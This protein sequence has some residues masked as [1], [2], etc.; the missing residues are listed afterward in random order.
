MMFS[1]LHL[2]VLGI[3]LALL[4]MTAVEAGKKGYSPAVW[5]FAGGLI[6]LLIVALLPFVNEK[7]NLPEAQR[8]SMIHA[9]L[10]LRRRLR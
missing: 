5:L 9:S 8:K 6:G 3:V 1:P 7:S 4:V 10:A 2:F